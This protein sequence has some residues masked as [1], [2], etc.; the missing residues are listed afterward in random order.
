MLGPRLCNRIIL[1]SKCHAIR[2][3]QIAEKD[4]IKKELTEEERRLA[5]NSFVLNYVL[6]VKETLMLS[7]SF[8]DNHYSNIV[9]QVLRSE[10]LFIDFTLLSDWMR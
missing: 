5:N 8:K 4:L 1:A 3:A 6:F 10:I 7:V 2:D 9:V